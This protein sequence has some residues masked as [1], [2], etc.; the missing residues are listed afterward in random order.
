MTDFLAPMQA[1][2]PILTV[3]LSAVMLAAGVGLTD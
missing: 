3:V 2:A 1:G